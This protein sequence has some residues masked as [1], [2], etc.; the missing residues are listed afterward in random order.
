MI[1]PDLELEIP[2]ELGRV[3]FVGIGGSG[4]S[5]IARMMHQAG[6]RVTGSDR[7]AN[8]STAALEEL[9]ISVAIGHD[10]ENV[11]DADT[12][13]V[14][15]ALW[16]DNPEYQRALATGMPVLHRSQALAWLARGK[17]VVSIAGAHGKTTSTGMVVTGLLGVGADPSFV[18]GG[19]IESLGVSSGP[20]TDELFV[21]EADES[22]KS[23][24]LYDTAVALI[25]NVDPEHLDF[26]G[27]R[28]AFMQAFVDFARGA[29]E[30]VVISADDPGAL[31]VLAA[32]R[33][34]T[35]DAGPAIRTFGEAADA[36]VRILSIDDSGPV[37]F[38]VEIDGARFDAQLS[39]YGRHNAVNAVGS[40]AVL[41]GLG[42][43]PGE[44]LAA[45][46]E[47][48]GTKRR[49]EFHAE[50]G[51]VR[52]YDDYAHHP[53]EVAALLESARAVVGEGRLIAIH[54]P[55]L[56]SRTSMF[57]REFAEA[58]E[59]GADHTVVLAV[60]GAREDPVPE[61][62]GA[63]VSNDFVDA[64]RV[65]YRPEWQDAAEY[66]AEFA[67][68]GDVM[69]TMSCGTV[70]RIIPQVVEALRGRFEAA[71]Q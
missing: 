52:V 8:Y 23:F 42:F 30:L 25:T 44:A 7:S 47:F 31:E 67:Q 68:P 29:R 13:V 28:E 36:D 33:A 19:I 62:T 50:V 18:N 3:H 12:L 17:R 26:Y 69:V 6:V 48:G 38:T 55:H 27:S 57:H 2:A 60:D 39:V 53:T 56:Y 45:I 41:T 4:M 32:L 34:E 24:L 63:L 37:R 40:L 20:G 54:Q 1:Y 46:A 14:T 51:G 58:L 15:G 16:Q 66:L 59:S 61:V 35:G 43:A 21:I 70:Y 5:G 64:S 65:A 11:G 9:G 49:F 71:A 22:D 10:A